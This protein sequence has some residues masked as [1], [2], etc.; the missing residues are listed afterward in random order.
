[1]CDEAARCI[2]TPGAG[3]LP[4]CSVARGNDERV[5]GWIALA[6]IGAALGRRRAA[7]RRS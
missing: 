2:P 4:S 6:A 1:V 7:R 3:R 5:G